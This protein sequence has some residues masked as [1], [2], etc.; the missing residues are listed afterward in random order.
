MMKPTSPSLKPSGNRIKPA[1]HRNALQ[2]QTD[3]R[4][5]IVGR[6]CQTPI[7]P[8]RRFTEMPYNATALKPNRDKAVALIIVLAFV[9]LLTGLA[10]AFLSRGTNNRQVAQSSFHDTDADLLARSALDI[11]VG[12]FKQEI[13]NGST[14]A[15]LPGVYYVPWTKA[16]GYLADAVVPLRR[17]AGGVNDPV[18]TAVPNLIRRSYRNDSGLLGTWIPCLAS[19]VNSN[20]NVSV[21]GRSISLARWNSH[22][23]CFKSLVRS[24]QALR[25]NI[26]FLKL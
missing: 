18:L 5:S 11:V 14:S 16:N 12:D 21:N 9:V 2:H 26:D 6:L 10:V 8:V 20:T 23:F 15:S 19:A 1:F 25:V 7:Q 3:C 13:V 17:D 22:Y 24:R 4:A